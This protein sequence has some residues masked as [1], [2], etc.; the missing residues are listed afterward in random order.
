[1][2]SVVGMT[3]LP[4]DKVDLPTFVHDIGRAAQTAFELP[5][6]MRSVYLVPLPPENC[7]V[8]DG[9]EI[10]FLLYT[11]PGKSVELKRRTVK[12]LNDV[13]QAKDWG[14]TVKVVVIIKEHAA[15][16]VGVGGVLRLDMT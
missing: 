6:H 7:T 4:L 12:A 8:K 13:V 2:V 11:A 3:D 9:Y 16:N 10:T 1:M 15:E 14:D 5:P